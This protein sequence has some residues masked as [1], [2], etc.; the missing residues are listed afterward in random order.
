M[1][2]CFVLSMF[3]ISCCICW[4]HFLMASGSYLEAWVLRHYFSLYIFS[5]LGLYVGCGTGDS[6]GAIGLTMLWG[7]YV[8]A[9]VLGTG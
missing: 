6:C 9:N 8:C 2:F 5:G 4:S 3:V 7:G 1:A